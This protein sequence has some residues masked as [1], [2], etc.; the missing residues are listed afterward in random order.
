MENVRRGAKKR[1]D[2]GGG[3]REEREG[4]VKNCY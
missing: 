1:E 3:G 2:K 4:E